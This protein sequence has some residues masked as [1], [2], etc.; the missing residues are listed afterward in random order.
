MGDRR[1]C[2]DCPSWSDDFERA[3][4]TDLGP[5]WTEIAGDSFIESNRLK[6]TYSGGKNA[7]VI[8]EQKPQGNQLSY[9]IQ[10]S[11]YNRA[12]GDIHRVIVN[13]VDEDNYYF[14]HVLCG[15]FPTV[16][17]IA[18]YRRALG[19]DTELISRNYTSDPNVR[20]TVCFD[21]D[22]FSV[23]DDVT[24]LLFAPAGPL[25]TDPPSDVYRAGLAGAGPAYFNDF[26]FSEHWSTNEKCPRCCCYCEHTPLDP[27]LHLTIEG[28]GVA[29][30]G[31]GTPGIVAAY[32]DGQY[33]DLLV[34]W[35]FPCGRWECEMIY[36]EPDNC[37]PVAQNLNIILFCDSGGGGLSAFRL[38]VNGVDHSPTGNSTCDP[39]Y[40]E[41][42]SG[43]LGA[44]SPSPPFPPECSVLIYKVTA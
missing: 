22:T 2:C 39:L 24:D 8:C 38:Q 29:G 23:Q 34:N 6:C 25:T 15:A 20:I 33:C 18:L 41:F 4:S 42:E 3:N 9:Y 10:V 37:P 31:D 11:L 5:D 16:G 36:D 35:S 40:L 1:C 17:T 14:V 27:E 26:Y 32:W 28:Q 7:L 19:I 21:G 13:Y 12:E 43:N 44:C 30:C